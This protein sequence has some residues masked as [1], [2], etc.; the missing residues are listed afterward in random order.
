MFKKLLVCS[1]FAGS[2]MSLHAQAIATA[3]RRGDAQIGVGYS[4][5]TPDYTQ[6]RFNGIAVYGDFDFSSHFGIE[7][8]FHYAK[9]PNKD[10]A[11]NPIYEKSYEIGGRYHR[12][13]NRFVP[14]AKVMY[15]RGVFNFPYYKVQTSYNPPAFSYSPSANLAYNLV[16]AGVGVDYRLTRILNVR[17]DY[18][19][20][21]WLG[22]PKSGLTPSL[23]TFG[24]AYHFR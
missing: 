7:G 11:V 4:N 8:E 16:A 9:S 14:Y 24:I 3:T 10:P 6:D 23:L 15:G 1:L 17:A 2:V 19:Y 18:E 12:T 22:F 21:R 13:Y 20:Q 5:V